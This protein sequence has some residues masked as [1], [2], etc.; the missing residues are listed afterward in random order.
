MN[1][2]F[3]KIGKKLDLEITDKNLSKRKN[4][5]VFWGIHAF[6][7]LISVIFSITD[8]YI[9]L[10]KVIMPYPY[11]IT[12]RGYL[13]IMGSNLATGIITLPQKRLNNL[14]Y[15]KLKRVALFCGNLILTISIYTLVINLFRF[16][17]FYEPV[18][19]S[20]GVSIAYGVYSEEKNVST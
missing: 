15:G 2:T 17:D 5:V 19:G 14:N 3:D 18:E 6:N 13:P 12:S 1:E 20:V 8:N 7:L 16:I 11:V 9:G 4:K 10:R